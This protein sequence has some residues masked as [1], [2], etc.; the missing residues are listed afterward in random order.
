MGHD[1]RNFSFGMDDGAAVF[2]NVEHLFEVN[3][4][5]VRQLQKQWYVGQKLKQTREDFHI[6]S[7]M[8]SSGMMAPRCWTTLAATRL[9]KSAA[10]KDDA[11]SNL[12]L[13]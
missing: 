11:P 1:M 13:R 4:L 9:P 2:C 5:S 3:G 7:F 8:A 12:L 10:I 6:S